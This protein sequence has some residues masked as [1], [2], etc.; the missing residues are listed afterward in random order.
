MFSVAPNEPLIERYRT[1]K[2]LYIITNSFQL[3][4]KYICTAN[5][6]IH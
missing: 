2:I 5:K 1:Q 4:L 6:N 3:S